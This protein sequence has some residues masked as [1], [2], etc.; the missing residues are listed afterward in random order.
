[1]E[2]NR[3]AEYTLGVGAGFPALAAT[4]D[5]PDLQVP[6]YQAAAGAVEASACRSYIGTLENSTEARI[7]IM[8]AVY[9]LIKEDTTLD[10]ATELQKAE[11][12]YNASN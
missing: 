9:K 7:L 12:E 2:L 8:N 5:H 10:I 1:M 11:D 6:F 3:N 4:L